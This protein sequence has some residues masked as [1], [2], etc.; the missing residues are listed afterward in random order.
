MSTPFRAGGSSSYDRLRVLVVDDERVA[1]N[2][3]TEL[4]EASGPNYLHNPWVSW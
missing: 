1:H 4:I 2:Y 3:L